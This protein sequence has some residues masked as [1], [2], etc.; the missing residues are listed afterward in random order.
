MG[1]PQTLRLRETTCSLFGVHVDLFIGSNGITWNDVDSLGI[2]RRGRTCMNMHS[3][4]DMSC[5]YIYIYCICIY[6]PIYGEKNNNLTATS[7]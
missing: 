3:N 5:V 7:L 1:F 6:L 4:T 2:H